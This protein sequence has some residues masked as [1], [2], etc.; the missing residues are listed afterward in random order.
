MATDWWNKSYNPLIT[1]GICTPQTTFTS[2]MPTTES[3]EQSEKYTTN[4]KQGHNNVDFV[5]VP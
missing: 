2:S 1:L 3:P 5:L 4:H